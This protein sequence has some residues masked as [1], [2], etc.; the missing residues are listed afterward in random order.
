MT[1]II[2]TAIPALSS[3][4]LT[5]LDRAILSSPLLICNHLGNPAV[6]WA[7]AHRQSD[8][9]MPILSHR[10]GNFDSRFCIA[11]YLLIYTR[12][13]RAKLL[14][15]ACPLL[16]LSPIFIVHTRSLGKGCSRCTNIP[17]YERNVRA[18][19]ALE[20]STGA[21]APGALIQIVP[22]EVHFCMQNLR[23]LCAREEYR[24]CQSKVL[25]NRHRTLAITSIIRCNRKSMC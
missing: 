20:A 24:P 15:L 25:K 17:Q 4:Y 18:Y 8:H 11:L 19:V 10:S 16:S 7:R 9:K 1:Q 2:R 12:F 14:S 23:K 6:G 22:K 5:Y 3:L 13:F 21:S